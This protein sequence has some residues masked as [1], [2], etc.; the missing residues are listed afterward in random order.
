MIE[1]SH[2]LRVI[3]YNPGNPWNKLSAMLFFIFPFRF[4]MMFPNSMNYEVFQ[5][6]LLE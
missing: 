4:T 6:R 3:R 5:S 2:I 1:N